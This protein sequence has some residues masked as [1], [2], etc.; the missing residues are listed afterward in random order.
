MPASLKAQALSNAR[1]EALRKQLGYPEGFDMD[2]NREAVIQ[3]YQRIHRT[4]NWTDHNG[5]PLT[6]RLTAGY[7]YLKFEKRREEQATVKVGDGTATEKDAIE[8]LGKFLDQPLSALDVRYHGDDPAMKKDFNKFLE[9]NEDVLFGRLLGYG[10]DAFEGDLRVFLRVCK[11][12]WSSHRVM[13]DV[14]GLPYE[15]MR[16]LLA[17][18]AGPPV[19]PLLY[20]EWG[21]ESEENKTAVANATLSLRLCSREVKDEKRNLA[22]L[23]EQKCHEMA[24]QD[25]VVMVKTIRERGLTEPSTLAFCTQG[26]TRLGSMSKKLRQDD[27]VECW[28]LFHAAKCFRAPTE[29]EHEAFLACKDRDKQTK[30]DK[31]KRRAMVKEA[32][33]PTDPKKSRTGALG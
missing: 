10:G 23:V 12:T 14:N 4:R 20:H 2:A 31:K 24:K 22:L 27:R 9:D 17:K 8:H 7:S 19:L 26:N 3:E 29:D 11:L 15:A 16:P 5:T 13:R 18:Q 1:K 32:G 6:L 28:V 21:P 30:A 33:A 25:E